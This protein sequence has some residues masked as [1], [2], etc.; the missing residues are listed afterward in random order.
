[1][2]TTEVLHLVVHLDTHTTLECRHEHTSFVV[3]LQ[4]LTG[5]LQMA[6]EIV[7]SPR[8]TKSRLPKP[9]P[10]TTSPCTW[11]G[12]TRRDVVTP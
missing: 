2:Y 3:L 10:S 1:L 8:F 9:R 4:H 6:R 12:E 7:A 5:V 11:I